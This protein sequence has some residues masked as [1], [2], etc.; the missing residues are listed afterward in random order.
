MPTGRNLPC[1]SGEVE[2]MKLKVNRQT[3]K[4]TTGDQ[5][6]HLNFSSGELKKK[7][8]TY[9]YTELISM[10]FVCLFVL[11]RPCNLSAIWRLSILPVTGLQI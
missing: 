10:R 9:M 11:S 3:D 5:K 7:A 1:G 4:R 8:T 2:N 6:A